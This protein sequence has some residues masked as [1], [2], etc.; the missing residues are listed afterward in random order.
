MRARLAAVLL[1]AACLAGPATAEEVPEWLETA[2]RAP[3]PRSSERAPAAVLLEEALVDATRAE[4]RWRVREAV[5]VLSAGGRR[6]GSLQAPQA[7][8][9]D[10]KLVSAWK[11]RPDGRVTRYDRKAVSQEDADGRHEFSMSKLHVFWPEEAR[12]GDV[13]AWEFQLASRPEA[14][15]HRWDFGWTRP[16]LRSRFGLKVPPDW[17]VRSLVLNG[18]DAPVTDG[19]YRLWEMRGLDVLLEEPLAPPR[20]DRLPSLLVSYGPPAAGGRSQR[21]DTWED[22]SRWYAALFGRQV[23]ADDTI[24]DTAAD[25]ARGAPS[26]LD[27]IRSVARF[28]QGVRYLNVAP[29]R[30]MVEP[31]PAPQILKNRF[32]DCEDKAVLTAALLREAGVAS[33]PILALTSDVGSVTPEFPA[34]NQFNHAILAIEEPPG[35]GLPAAVETR[36]AGRLIIFD[37]TSS[38]TGLGDLPHYLQGTHAVLATAAGGGLIALPVVPPETSRRRSSLQVSFAERGGLDVRGS[39]TY[40]GQYAADMRAHYEVVRGEQRTQELQSWIAGRFGRGEVRRL[41]VSGVEVPGEPVVK[42]VDFWMPLPG[43]ELQGLVTIPAMFALGSR[44]ERLDPAARTAPVRLD[45]GY[46]E[47]D[48]WVLT[49]PAGWRILEPLPAASSDGPQGAYRLAVKLEETTLVVERD[50]TMRAGTLP[51][52]DYPAIRRFLDEV[53]R[54]DG[55]ALAIER[56]P[57][58]AD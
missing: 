53:F 42:S 26:K 24:R 41:D 14:F 38:L 36:V 34:P 51:V 58:A 30:S 16:T 37:P 28:V 25:L 3:M 23:I 2:M 46:Q 49:V 35:S 39:Q 7:I 13:V 44:A 27:A 48:R 57:P 19:G 40:T 1:A 52:S 5:R 8:N 43:K 18:A 47:S 31:H 54:G 15:A 21:F 32:G 12:V 56:T 4:V 50:L 22:V 9:Q 11:V 10:F 17:T 33:H 20:R 29:G 6:E 55:L 45:A